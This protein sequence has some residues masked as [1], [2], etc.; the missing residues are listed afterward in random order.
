[1]KE[2]Q[3]GWTEIR[4]LIFEIK[5]INPSIIIGI[6]GGSVLD[7]IKPVATLFD[8]Q[9]DISDVMNRKITPDNRN[10]PIITIPT[11]SGTGSEVTPFSVI[12]NEDTG[13]KQSIGPVSY[14]PDVAI[15]FKEISAAMYVGGLF[16][17]FDVI[18]TYP[19][20]FIKHKTKDFIHQLKLQVVVGEE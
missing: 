8:K 19:P 12:T 7:A 10:I 18:L 11:T 1:M 15:F 2:S 4:R 6:G 13:V 20:L 16:V 17:F 3:P 14:F 9:I 5:K